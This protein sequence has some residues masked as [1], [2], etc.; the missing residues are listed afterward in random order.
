MKHAPATRSPG[1][2]ALRCPMW[3]ASSVELGP[4][5]RLRRRD[6]VEEFLAG[7]PPP[8]P[9]D[10][11]LHHGD[12]R[13]RPAEGGGA[14]PE[15]EPRELAEHPR[16]IAGVRVGFRPTM[17]TVRRAADPVTGRFVRRTSERYAVDLRVELAGREVA[18][19]DVSTTGLFVATPLPVGDEIDLVLGSGRARAQSF[20]GSTAW[21]GPA[22]WASC[23]AMPRPG[24]S[25]RST[26]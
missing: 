10:L 3:I 13:G 26:A 11:V 6:E 19:H 23:S 21:R 7:Q 4:G 2:P 16:S 17:R 18:V 9:H 15:K 12:V 14:E 20:T 5:M 8:P 1:Q 22:A 25:P 24:S